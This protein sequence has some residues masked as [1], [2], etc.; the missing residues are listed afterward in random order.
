MWLIGADGTGAE[1]IA[2][3]NHPAWA[4]PTRP[5]AAFAWQ[6]CSRLTCAFDGSGSWGGDGGIV[7]YGWNFGDGTTDSGATATHSYA[8]SGTYTVTLTVTDTAGVTGTR[9]QVLE[10]HANVA[11]TAW[12]TYACSGRQCT[13]DGRGS[14]DR[15]GS[16][17]TYFW[18]FGDGETASSSPGPT[19]S[20]TYTGDGTFTVQLTVTDDSGASSTQLVVI[21][22]VNASPVA[23]FTYRCTWL[24]CIFDASASSDPDG[25]ITSYGWNF[26]DGTAGEGASASRTYAAP[27]PYAVTLSVTDNLGATST[28]TK[29]ITAVPQPMHVGDLDGTSAPRQNLWIATVAIT[30]HDSGHAVVSNAAVTGVWNDGTTATCTTNADGR[31]TVSRPGIPKRTTSVSF[32]VTNVTRATFAYEPVDNH[33]LDGGSNGTAIVVSRR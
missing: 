25:N 9:T 8:A 1:L 30:V 3:G 22:I 33:D 20:H 12:F 7:S 11:P 15:D 2:S 5:V 4:L 28:R 13:F 14:F 10:V 23:S 26:G 17:V 24:T 16:I 31:C 18:S 19:V 6:G 32:S 29:T 21:N 27:G